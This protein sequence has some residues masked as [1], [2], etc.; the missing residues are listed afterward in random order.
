MDGFARGLRVQVFLGETHQVHHQPRYAAV[1]DL[2]RREGA[3]GATVT[4]GI[5]GFGG[6]GHLHTSHL[7]DLSVDLP[8]VVTWVDLPERV[9]RLL[10]AVRELAA[11]GLVTVDEVQASGLGGALAGAEG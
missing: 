6:H 5:A 9:E 10:P 3:A 1:L 8:V 2:L 4:R 7:L 11:G